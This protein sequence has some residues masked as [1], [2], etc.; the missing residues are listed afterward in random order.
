MVLLAAGYGKRIRALTDGPKCLLKVDG[1]SL[2]E[3]HFKIWKSLGIKKI[4]LVLGY[5]STL[6]REIAE[7]YMDDFD[8]S[9]FLNKDYE[10]QGNTFS[11]YLGIRNVS[12]PCLIFDADLIYESSV[13]AGFLD[14]GRENQML[15]GRGEL[16]DIECTKVLVDA[17]N[18][19]RILADK[20]A[21]EEEELKEYRFVGEAVGVLKFAQE[22]TRHLKEM[23]EEF[24]SEEANVSLN[25]EHLFNRFIREEDVGTHCF[26]KGRWIEI[27]TPEDFESARRMFER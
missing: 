4:H 21:V 11:L 1:V 26:E 16:S 10:R 14:N 24:L 25:W 15:V 27:D 5:K 19:I 18:N 17:G 2:L 22:Q 23:A 13:L 8:L 20:R 6:I 9:F 12:G 3:R 7:Q